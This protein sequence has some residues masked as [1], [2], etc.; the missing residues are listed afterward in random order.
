MTTRLHLISHAS[1]AAIAQAAFPAD[2]PLDE[3]GRRQAMAAG[4]DV[5]Q[6]RVL[7]GPESRCGQTAAALGLIAEVEPLLRDCDF[8]RWSGRTLA[9]VQTAEPDAVHVWLSD[10]GAVPHGGESVLDVIDRAV[11]W[12]SGLAGGSI[13][14]ITN[15]AVIRAAVVH[16]IG[17]P[18]V[19]FW[20]VD[21]EPLARVCLT[22]RA[23]RWRLRIHSRPR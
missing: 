2:E 16:A 6:A 11:S 9:E 3:R 4:R 18:A 19:S 5:S 15:P 14:A 10:P 12:L 13:T 7:C 17:A 8:G 23:G 21:V 1:T 20:R 22:G